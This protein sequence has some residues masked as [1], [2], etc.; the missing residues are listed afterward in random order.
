MR[1]LIVSLAFMF[2]PGFTAGL[3]GGPEAIMWMVIG[4]MCFFGYDRLYP[5]A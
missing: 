4:G 2:A 1:V 3:L 5:N